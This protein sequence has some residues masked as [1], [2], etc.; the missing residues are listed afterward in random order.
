MFVSEQCRD[1][2]AGL[3]L[4]LNISGDIHLSRKIFTFLNV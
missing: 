2:K 4:T 1:L 3:L